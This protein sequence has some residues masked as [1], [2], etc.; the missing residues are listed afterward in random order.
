MGVRLKPV[1]DQVIVITGASSGIGLTTAR[2][3]AKEGA[4]LVLAAR[5]E[6]DLKQLADEI[7]SAGG[8]AVHVVA[9]VGN[10][11]DVR[12]IADA[13]TQRFGG[14]DTWVNNAGVGMFGRIEETSLED[15]RRLFET[16]FWGVVHGSRIAAEHL[17][18]RGGALIN[19]GSTVSDRSIPLQGVYASSKFAVRGFTDALRM[20]LEEAGA[21]VSVTLI[22]PTSID[23]P[24]LQ[25]AKNYMPEDPNLPPPVYAPETVAQ[26]ILY[27]AAHPERDIFVGSGGK[28]FSLMEKVAPRLTDRYMEKALF[29]QQ[30]SSRRVPNRREALHHAG[31]DG[32]RESGVY[33][34]HVMRT[35][36]YTQASLHPLLTVAALMGAGVA[37]AAV[38]G[39]A[40]GALP[41]LGEQAR[42]TAER[43]TRALQPTRDWLDDD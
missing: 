16:N 42:R 17:R 7:N 21:P 26:A 8:Q 34:G 31:N 30:K 3:A 35:S 43:A 18:G 38:A 11:A 12:R 40:T 23:T 36:A 1:K 2:M 29:R 33:P 5:S 20:E 19:V 41:G 4:K 27:A 6:E 24:Y 14:F 22:K 25:H 15:M 37:V 39:V 28:L 13:A 32:L 10:E 9:D